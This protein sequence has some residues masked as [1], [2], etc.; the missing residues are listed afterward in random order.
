MRALLGIVAIGLICAAAPA[1]A[2][3]YDPNY[4]VCMQ[5]IER[6]INY[7]DCRFVSMADCQASASGRA[8]YC[9]LNP[10]FGKRL[11]RSR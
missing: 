8:G 3:T 2:Q 11:R 9:M 5:V 4:P 1:S 7:I 10:Y 6:D